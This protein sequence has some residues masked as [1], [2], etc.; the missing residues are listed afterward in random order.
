MTG[1]AGGEGS[2]GGR[3]VG[4]DPAVSG[5]RAV[6]HGGEGGG[7]GG[8]YH[9]DDDG[10]RDDDG[11]ATPIS[12]PVPPGD[13]GVGFGRWRPQRGVVMAAMLVAMATGGA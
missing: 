7:S 13:Y 1:V 3:K 6:L 10:Y 9:D 2:D 12:S 8:S 4:T 11:R 5:A